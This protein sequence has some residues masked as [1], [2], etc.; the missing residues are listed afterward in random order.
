MNLKP[1]TVE[2]LRRELG[3]PAAAT[4]ITAMVGAAVTTVAWAI[5]PLEPAKRA[6]TVEYVSAREIGE[7]KARLTAIEESQRQMRTELRG[8]IQDLRSLV[9]QLLKQH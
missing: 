9:Q 5:A 2:P 3:W 1:R 4:L 7:V 8:D 6:G